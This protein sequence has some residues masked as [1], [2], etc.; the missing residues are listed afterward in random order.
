MY[1]K[2]EALNHYLE[3]HDIYSEIANEYPDL[4]NPYLATAKHN[5]GVFFDENQKY[6]QALNYYMKALSIRK[7]LA[8]EDPEL[9]KADQLITG[10][11]MLTIYQSLLEKTAN[12]AYLTDG[13][14]LMND[15]KVE[16]D[17][18]GSNKSV[19][20][21]IDS[22]L[23][24]F[25]EYFNQVSIKE[26]KW[27]KLINESIDKEAIIG[28]MEDENEKLEKLLLHLEGM[29]FLSSKFPI[30]QEFKLRSA[31][32]F[33]FG[34]WH[35]ILL[36]QFDLAEKFLAKSLEINPNDIPAQVNYAHALYLKGDK[37]KAL[38]LYK[39]ILEQQSGQSKFYDQLKQELFQ[40]SLYSLDVPNFNELT[41]MLV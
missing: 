15:I 16:L 3:A 37:E 13:I 28:S 23:Q 41:G 12:T 40:L 33:I 1:D 7:S 38:K 35:L 30:H 25:E 10:I 26:L 6:E 4:F 21:G 19:L 18:M 8:D 5:L 20:E 24:Y 27:T 11:N 31:E 17:K 36:G 22:D 29:D 14:S 32:S 2:D 39:K 34:G 9:F